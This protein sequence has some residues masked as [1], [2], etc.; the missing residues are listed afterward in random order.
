MTNR[1]AARSPGP[2][3]L[4]PVLHR[5]ERDALRH[6]AS[7]SLESGRAGAGKATRRPGRLW[8]SRRRY[9]QLTTEQLLSVLDKAG[10]ES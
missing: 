2:L 1:R 6:A 4:E 9:R 3:G 7:I 8:R 10:Q 5:A